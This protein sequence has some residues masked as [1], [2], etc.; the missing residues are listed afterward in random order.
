LFKY[1]DFLCLILVWKDSQKFGLGVSLSS[2]RDSGGW[3]WLA[4]VADYYPAGN[5]M[6][7]FTEN[8]FQA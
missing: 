2:S 7:E 1:L 8:V 6:G 4:V 5:Y 3:Y